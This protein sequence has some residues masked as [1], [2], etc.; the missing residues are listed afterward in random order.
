[1]IMM[2][3]AI[4]EYTL[5]NEKP[6]TEHMWKA[7]DFISMRFQEYIALICIRSLDSSFCLSGLSR[8]R[9]V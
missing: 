8:C 3:S 6:I 7:L 1:M 4:E 5:Q 2:H 9:K